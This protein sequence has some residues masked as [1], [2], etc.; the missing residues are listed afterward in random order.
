LVLAD[1]KGTNAAYFRWVQVE[2]EDY[3]LYYMIVQWNTWLPLD[4]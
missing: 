1:D 2:V 4:L 3:L